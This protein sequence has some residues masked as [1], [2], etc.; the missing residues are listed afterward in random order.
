MLLNF[1]FSNLACLLLVIQPAERGC[2]AAKNRTYR[3]T[4]IQEAQEKV[5]RGYI[6]QNE[7]KIEHTDK[8]SGGSLCALPGEHSKK[9]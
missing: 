6:V 7:E 5:G 2:S 1:Y 8:N 3:Y 4:S 9:K